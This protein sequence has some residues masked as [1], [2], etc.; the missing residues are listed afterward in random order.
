V[1]GE[2]RSWIRRLNQDSSFWEREGEKAFY[3][4]NNR[5][6]Y[7]ANGPEDEPEEMKP[8]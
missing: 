3:W 6:K 4:L 2:L 1:R 7:F 5:A 8:M